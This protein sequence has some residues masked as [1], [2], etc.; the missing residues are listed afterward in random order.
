[1]ISPIAT[2]NSIFIVPYP[3]QK[4]G[5]LV[6]ENE[7]IADTTE[8][9]QIAYDYNERRSNSI[10]IKDEIVIRKLARSPPIPIPKPSFIQNKNPYISSNP[11]VFKK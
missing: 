4:D 8:T 7:N 11:Y 3:Y 9:T 2:E 6:G 10:A 1:L 5:V